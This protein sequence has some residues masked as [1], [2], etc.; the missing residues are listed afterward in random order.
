MSDAGELSFLLKMRDE[1]SAVIRGFAGAVQSSS[2][3]HQTASSAAKEHGASLDHLVNKAKEAAEAFAAVWTANEMSRE[4]LGAW[5]KLEVS[6]TRIQQVSGQTQASLDGLQGTL[7]ELAGH[8]LDQTAGQLANVALQATRLG[9]SG[10]QVKEFTTTVSQLA[11]ATGMS[12]SAIEHGMSTILAATG[13]S[14]NGAK[15]FGEV[16]AEL[17]N[18]TRDGG[19]GLMQAA[20]ALTMMT[21]GMGLSSEKTLA[22]SSALG[23]LGLRSRTAGMAVGQAMQEFEKLATNDK[24][25]DQLG[26]MSLAL[27]MTAE[28]FKEMQKNDP[29]GVLI[30]FEEAIRKVQASGGS[31]DA[32][33]K[34]FNLSGRMTE[35]TFIALS[36]QLDQVKEKMDAAANSA[37]STK[38]K[39]DAEALSN[40]LT[41]QFHAAAMAVEDFGIA[42][43]KAAEPLALPVIKQA[44][45]DIHMLFDAFE[46]LPEPIKEVVAGLLIG[47]PM[48][49]A[50]ATA[51][52]FLTEVI[53]TGMGTL[54]SMSGILGVVTKVMMTFRDAEELVALEGAHVA[55]G[56]AAAAE[57]IAAT[58]AAARTAEVGF[59]GLAGRLLSITTYF[60]A[61]REAGI[62]AGGFLNSV[63][64][65]SVKQGVQSFRQNTT[66]GQGMSWVGS[67]VLGVNSAEQ[68]AQK[69]QEEEERAKR[70]ADDES[71]RNSP[72]G[73]ARGRQAERSTSGANDNGGGGNPQAAMWEGALK[74]LDDYETKLGELKTQLDAIK[75]LQALPADQRTISSEQLQIEKNIV[76]EKIR[77]LDP[78]NKMRDSWR[79]QLQAATAYTKVQ[80]EQAAIEKAVADARRSNPRFSASDETEMRGAMKA[81]NTAEHNKSFAEDMTT[82]NQQ[83]AAA[84][85]ISQT[86]KDQLQ[87]DQQ[88]AAV[89]KTKGW[90]DAQIAQY[91]Q[92]L[93]LTKQI[94]ER[95]AQ[96]KALNP[97]AASIQSY[98][99]QLMLLKKNLDAGNMS[100]GEY[101]REKA[102]LDEDTLSARDPIGAIV[103]SQQEEIA[104]LGVIGQYRE[105]DLKTLQEIT[106]LKKQGIKVDDQTAGQLQGGNRAIQDIKEAQSQMQGLEDSFGSGLGNA[107]SGAL[108]GQKGAFQKFA[109]DF[110]K[111]LFDSAWKNI[112]KQIEGQMSGGMNGML[113]G[114]FGKAK[115]ATS[116][117]AGAGEKQMADTMSTAAM[118]VQAANVTINSATAAATAATGGATAEGAAPDV[119]GSTG[120]QATAPSAGIS[121]LVST[122]A[123]AANDNSPSGSASGG[124]G[125]DAHIATIAKAITSGG[126]GIGSDFKA[127]GGMGVKDLISKAQSALKGA[128]GIGS[129]AVAGGAAAGAAG[130]AAGGGDGLAASMKALK[131]FEGFAPKAKWDVNHYRAGYGSDTTTDPKTGAVRSIQKGDTVSRAEGDADLQR[132]VQTEFMPKVRGQVGGDKFDGMSPE[133][134]G[135]L[136]SMG[137]NYGKLPKDVARAAR[138][139]STEDVE[140]AMRA[141]EH[142]NGGINLKRRDQEADLFGGK[143]QMDQA[144]KLA[145]Q[146]KEQAKA[147]QDQVQAASKATQGIGS[148]NSGI[149]EIGTKAA[150]AVPDMSSFSGS[151]EKM[152]SSL[153]SG[154]GGGGGGGLGGIGGV[155]SG[156]FSAAHTGGVVGS[157]NT[158]MLRSVN[159]NVFNFAPRFHDGMG[160]DEFPAVLQK[161]ERVLTQNQDQRSTAL[162]SRMAAAL[163]NKSTP[164]GSAPVTNPASGAQARGGH[165][166]VNVYTPNAS[167][168]RSSQSQ[169]AATTHAT[170]RRANAKHN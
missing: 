162:M 42:I 97:Q 119:T 151:I 13:E 127:S 166:T 104:Q 146:T 54:R 106:A 60:L 72:S 134:Q 141:H 50:A 152:V 84:A 55:A 154:A 128:S 11:T 87:I 2:A 43:G 121:K 137:Y 150:G 19:E 113:G 96:F 167:S 12:T 75:N 64:P 25:S 140:K 10:T 32:F 14:A 101:N 61:A 77:A 40:T 115:D 5:A 51:F 114:L 124:I 56:S 95:T 133:Q 49:I 6:M 44:V 153:A 70:E 159:P 108:S 37:G 62:L 81:T 148:L 76:A 66:I 52:K 3:A 89:A 18:K 27:G 98:N 111:Q 123:G 138:S 26:Q 23:N 58:G 69:K 79:E 155:V 22:L 144:A 57:G 8:S 41:G 85:A 125:S 136:T 156:L 28:Q 7:E 100:Q 102:K 82:A 65:D 86:S 20:Q 21:A 105:A 38:L 35:T 90:T 48:F 74:G 31:V 53:L 170:M 83:L 29:S 147:M 33:L 149:G 1:A 24:M 122:G 132:R 45:A 93:E 73:M 168:F 91:K 112:W 131:G 165:T 67:H 160:S 117:L 169:I 145:S 4:T 107:I 161:G 80:Q 59:A 34:Q 158:G 135:A 71:F 88:I 99:D 94:E 116:S 118:T 16:F 129:D 46:A 17:A 143:Q 68:D 78:M 15:H 120:N 130:G 47:V 63:L 163:S 126:G 164:A 92:V 39:D 30:K 109:A 9:V 36:K 110:G 139:G 142:D 103:E 157:M